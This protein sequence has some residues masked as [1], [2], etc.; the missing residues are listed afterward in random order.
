MTEKTLIQSNPKQGLEILRNLIEADKLRHRGKSFEIT[1][2]SAV[3]LRLYDYDDRKLLLLTCLTN[4]EVEEGLR[5]YPFTGKAK[6][7]DNVIWEYRVFTPGD[8][9]LGKGINVWCAL[10]HTSPFIIVS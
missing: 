6:S 5:K 2:E 4:E 10:S 1:N 7:D 3:E 9:P 8:D